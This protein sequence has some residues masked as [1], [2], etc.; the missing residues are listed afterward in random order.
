M[1]VLGYILQCVSLDIFSSVCPWIYL[2]RLDSTVC[3]FKG[4]DRIGAADAGQN[5]PLFL[6]PGPSK[7]PKFYDKARFWNVP[8]TFR[9]HPC[10]T[11]KFYDCR[12]LIQKLDFLT[13]WVVGGVPEGQT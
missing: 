2:H 13:I 12:Y 7:N 10:A 1:Y 6:T 8:P 3:N 5:N 11:K 9:A 4:G